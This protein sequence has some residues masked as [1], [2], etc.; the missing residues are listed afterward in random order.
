MALRRDREL[1]KFEAYLNKEECMLINSIVRG[2]H[3]LAYSIKKCVMRQMGWWMP[4]A[5]S[6]T[7]STAAAAGASRRVVCC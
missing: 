5:R 7:C 2:R 6:L 3:K 4:G 1:A